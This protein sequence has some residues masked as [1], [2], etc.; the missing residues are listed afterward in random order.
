M[1]DENY[2]AALKYFDEAVRVG[3]DLES[4]GELGD[5]MDLVY[6]YVSRGDVE[7][8][9]GLTE[10]LIKDREAAIEILENTKYSRSQDDQELLSNLHGE[11][12]QLYMK[13][14]KIKEAEKHLLKQVSYNL[15]GSTDYLNNK[16]F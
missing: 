1:D 5:M 13:A 8:F 16:E 3:T 14:G 9:L 10:E 7:E 12:A 11:T 15:S 2:R 4:T 6:A